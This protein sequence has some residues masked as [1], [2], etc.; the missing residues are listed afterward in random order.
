MKKETEYRFR[1]YVC[2]GEEWES[3]GYIRAENMIK[4]AGF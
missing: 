1:E 4:L 2:G 3:E